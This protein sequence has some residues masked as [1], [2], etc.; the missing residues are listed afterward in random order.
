MNAEALEMIVVPTHEQL[1][2]PVQIGDRQGVRQRHP[3][4]H[5]RMNIAQHHLQLQR[6]RSEGLGHQP[7]RSS[8]GCGLPPFFDGLSMGRRGSVKVA[9]VT[10]PVNAGTAAHSN[11]G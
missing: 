10:G 4:P 1:N 9:R 7:D 11:F 3:P 6:Q 2:D 8:A 5:G